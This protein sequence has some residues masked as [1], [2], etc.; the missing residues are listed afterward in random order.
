[1]TSVAQPEKLRSPRSARQF[2]AAPARFFPLRAEVP[3]LLRLAFSA[4]SVALLGAAYL[5]LTQQRW[6]DETIVPGFGTLLGATREVL[7][8]P[9]LR[10][11]LASSFARVTAGFLAA[12]LLAVPLGI[13]AGA[14]RLGSS[15]LEPLAELLR[16]IPVPALVPLV[17]IV[18]GI[19]EAAKI[20]LVFLGTFFQ[21]LLSTA[22]E[23]RRVPLRLVQV[24][25]S[26]GA[27][28]LEIVWR[29]LAPAASPG[30]SQALRMCNGWA[31]S[32]VVVAE[33]VAATEGLGF[34]VLRFYR[35]IQTP[36]IYVYLLVFGVVGLSLD[37]GF[38]LLHRRLFRWSL[39]RAEA[40]A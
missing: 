9:E 14:F 28:R 29:V 4:M 40:G 36:S 35:F 34:R 16:Y 24:S 1:M 32:Y 15:L 7:T 20:L 10:S 8:S 30:I 31:W 11:D 17:M 6:V 5:W 33:L 3:R 25:Q 19:D 21:L 39:S 37:Y 2:A 23:V 18:A 12:A 13:L 26:L 22:D 38:R 27:N